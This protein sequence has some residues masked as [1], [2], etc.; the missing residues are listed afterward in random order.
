MAPVDAYRHALAA[1]ARHQHREAAAGYQVPVL[2]IATDTERALAWEELLTEV[3]R[4]SGRHPI[5][6]RV[7]HLGSCGLEP[8]AGP[9]GEDSH[10]TDS[11]RQRGGLRRSRTGARRLWERRTTSRLP[12]PVG[13]P[14]GHQDLIGT[15]AALTDSELWLLDALGR[16]PFLP[17]RHLVA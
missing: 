12:Q 8:L 15:G 13:G 10:Q 5:A 14:L 16:H 11:V 6:S 7:V 2:V 1:L 4:A 9:A 3:T 17:L